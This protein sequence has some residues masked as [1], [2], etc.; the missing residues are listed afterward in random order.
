MTITQMK[1]L[2]AERGYSYQK[3]S[4]LSGIPV[5]TIQKIFRGETTHPRFET[6]QALESCFAPSA[7][8]P[9]VSSADLTGRSDHSSLLCEV[10]S[11]YAADATKKQGEYTLDDYYA[12]PE[13][14]RFE[15]IDGVL[16]EMNSPTTFHQLAAGEI[17][18]QIANF[19]L[20]HDG[21]CVPFISPMDVQ[22]DEDNR[23]MVEPDV[24]IVCDQD[25]ILGKNI[26]GAPD[27]ILEVISPSTRRRDYFLKLNKYREA[28]VKE[29]WL[30][31]PYQRYI[32]TYYFADEDRGVG[33][34]PIDA[35]IPVQLFNGELVIDLKH[36]LKWLPE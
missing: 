21:S 25:R 14:K 6:L 10:R 15:L 3:I 12:L 24:I 13:D 27:F 9:A 29:Y 1:K 19:I 33:I 30:V 22:L 34:H 16:F 26:F 7:G 8:Q 32:L 28:N 11:P 35:E 17:H 36:V 31:D 5:S 18:R 23:T 2:K 4:E 20:E